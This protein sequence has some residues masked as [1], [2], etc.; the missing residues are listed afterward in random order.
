MGLVV[1]VC[2]NCLN[3]VLNIHNTA[4]FRLVAPVMREEAKEEMKTGQIADSCIIN[5]SDV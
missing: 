4:V 5:V 1:F 2:F 3:A